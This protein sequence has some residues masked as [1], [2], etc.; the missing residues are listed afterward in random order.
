V[1]LQSASS[2]CLSHSK[3]LN[4]LAKGP[5]LEILV[6]FQSGIFRR[7]QPTGIGLGAFPEICTLPETDFEAYPIRNHLSF[8][9]VVAL[10][11]PES[12]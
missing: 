9:C 12:D 1:H 8:S 7:C 5:H 2:F 11:F 6:E 10:T 3:S 4:A